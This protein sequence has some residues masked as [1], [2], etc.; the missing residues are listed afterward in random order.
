[1]GMGVYLHFRMVLV[2]C[3]GGNVFHLNTTEKNK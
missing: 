2:Y 3:P 1:M